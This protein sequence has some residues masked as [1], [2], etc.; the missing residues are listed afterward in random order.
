MAESPNIIL[1]SIDCWRGDHLG[2]T[3]GQVC[4]PNLDDLASKATVFRQAISVGGWTRPAMM[5]LFTSQY[6]S[7]C[8]HASLQRIPADVTMLS[9]VLNS[10]GY[11]TA[12]FNTNPVCGSGGGFHRGFDIFAD[13]TTNQISSKLWLK[14]CRV[15]G[16][17]K[18]M[19][20]LFS[21]AF[22]HKTLALFGFRFLPES[23]AGAAELTNAAVSWF[24]QRSHSPFFLWVHYMDL[25]WPYRLSKRKHQ[26]DEIARAWRD[27]VTYKKIIKTRG[28]FDPGI[29]TRQHWQ[30]LYREEL[31][32]IDEQIGR[33]IAELKTKGLWDNT[34][35]VVTGDHGEEFFEHASWAHSWNQLFDEGVHVPLIIRSP[36]Q[37][38]AAVVNQ[39]VS[40]LEVAPTI[41]NLAGFQPAS[42]M[43]GYNMTHL[44]S[45]EEETAL[46]PYIISEMLGHPNSYRYRMAVRT[47]VQRYIYDLEQP[48]TA[49]LYN[50]QEDLDEKQSI[51]LNDHETARQYD[52]LRFRHI[53]PVIPNLMKPEKLDGLGDMPEEMVERLRD[54]GYLA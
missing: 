3:G 4:T 52:D 29:Q 32:S 22:I 36:G 47:E 1:L 20:S 25:H 34:I 5:A 21:H 44:L 38:Q 35:I 37:K 6:A 9:E 41:L 50:R 8:N 33:L 23:A 39:Q 40:S 54:L 12:G 13:L 17:L 28:R 31:Q 11:Q 27:R 14:L 7:K 51:Y 19:S 26:P 49:Y 48:Q 18:V 45:G 2:A 43:E 15:R 30:T 24:H 10:N 46:R 42:T 16:F 53:A